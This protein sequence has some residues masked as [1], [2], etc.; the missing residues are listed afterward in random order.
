MPGKVTK[1]AAVLLGLGALAYTSWVLEVL[2]RTGLDP[3][4]TYV[5]ELAAAD[6]P[7]GGLFRATDLV[8]GL[9][10]LA[11][12][13][14]GLAASRGPR[15]PRG[16]RSPRRPR[17][18]E[19]WALGGWIA[20]AVFGAATAVDSRLPLSCAPTADPECAARETAG[21]VPATHTAHAVSSSLAVTGAIAAMIALTVAARRYGRRRP[22]ARTGPALVV[23]E[24]A[25]TAWTLAAVAAFEAGKGTWALGAGQR[26]QVLLVAVWLAVLAASLVRER[27]R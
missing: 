3:V 4:R 15:S 14:T 8:A 19:R 7:L 25:A 22:L 10:V 6:Q 12:A 26:L 27:P 13:L 2:V 21:L 24:L 17:P 18:H 9:L 23:L 16:S 20:L 1:A 5:S 11:G